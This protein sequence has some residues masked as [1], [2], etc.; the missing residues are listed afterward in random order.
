MLILFCGNG[1]AF[2]WSVLPTFRWSILYLRS[3]MG[4]IKHGK[5]LLSPSK[6]SHLH[7]TLDCPYDFKWH[8][9]TSWKLVSWKPGKLAKVCRAWQINRH[10]QLYMRSF[11]AHRARI[12]YT[13]TYKLNLQNWSTVRQTG[14]FV[15]VSYS[16]SSLQLSLYKTTLNIRSVTEAPHLKF[17]KVSTAEVC[18]CE[19]TTAITVMD[20][21][22]GDRDIFSGTTTAVTR[23][24]HSS[25]PPEI[26][27]EWLHK[28]VTAFWS[29]EVLHRI[30]V[31]S[32]IFGYV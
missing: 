13:A 28:S 1:A 11:H 18:S 25:Q 31:A 2:K 12:L 15:Y 17:S 16:Q 7:S 6:N 29:K 26:R 27:T 3:S 9:E 30:L 21:E 14:A 10:G 24:P 4:N 8:T 22:G 23:K 19:W 32:N 5:Y 20:L